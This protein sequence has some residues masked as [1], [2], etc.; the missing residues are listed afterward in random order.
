MAILTVAAHL[1]ERCVG[2]LAACLYHNSTGLFVY[3][4]RCVDTAVHACCFPLSPALT[5][6]F[7]WR[8]DIAGMPRQV[9]HLQGKYRDIAVAHSQAMTK[10][11]DFPRTPK[12]N[13][14]KSYLS[15]MDR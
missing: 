1:P 7:M 14:A 10:I 11:N 2:A 15:K 5:L 6:A 12:W 3:H 9:V 4:I 8:P 13:I